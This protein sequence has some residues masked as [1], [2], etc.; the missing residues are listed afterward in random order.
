MPKFSDGHYKRQLGKA[1]DVTG[2]ASVGDIYLNAVIDV[3]DGV[4]P[5]DANDAITTQTL[6]GRI[7][8]NGGAFTEGVSTNGL[9]FDVPVIT[10][11]GNT[12]A[13]SLPKPPLALWAIV[14]GTLSGSKTATFA[15]LRGNA[16]DSGALSTTLPRV[17]MTV[18]DSN[19]TGE[20]KLSSTVFVTGTVRLVESF[21]VT[22]GG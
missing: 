10:G 15:R 6:I 18:S 21:E 8:L 3:Y 7:T 1:S 9:V 2:A 19:G 20:L 22:M 17:Q 14:A 11:S 5:N 13:V 4:A 12:K 16:A